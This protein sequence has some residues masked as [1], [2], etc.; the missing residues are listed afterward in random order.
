MD[1]ALAS[2]LRA[3]ADDARS[4]GRV[5]ADR[6]RFREDGWLVGHDREFARSLAA[7]GWIGMTW[8]REVG[9]GGRPPIER[10]VVYEALIGEGAPL[11][12]SYFADRQVGP[13]LL[14]FGTPEQV[15]RWLPGILSGT[16]M[17]CIGLSEPDAGSDVASI[18]T[19][20][21]VDDRGDWHVT[22]SKVWTSGAA[23]ADWCYL[24]VR[25][26]VDAPAHRGLSEL[27]VDMRSP[28]IEVRPIVDQTGDRHF[29]EVRF[30]EV[31]VPGDH[32]IGERNGSFGQVMRQMEHERG[33][34]DRLVS[35]RQLLL[36]C[37]P[38]AA[39]GSPLVRQEIAALESS[40]RIGRFLV[41][42][43]V[44]GQA[45]RGFSAATKTFC[46]EYEQRV[47]AFCAAVLGVAAQ[48]WSDGD[49]GVDVD[50]ADLPERVARGVVY[51]PAY[52]L[53]GGTTQVLRNI[54]GERLLGL[55]RV[56]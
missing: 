13:T 21:L 32:L 41:L 47:T 26:D 20:A 42:R 28:G 12:S 22:G 35:N 43:E 38:L 39:T 1:F 3:L 31:V 19:R 52:T 33:G 29:C 50:A 53:M 23:H 24:V 48:A 27:V 36:D 37:L 46:T 2:A 14:Q 8:P 25:T 55:P 10:F 30:D 7:R 11:A 56:R 17:W 6:R 9:G 5:G 44:L 18:R 15:G 49:G 16:S 51:A 45:P 40:Y 54:I 34:I 4:V